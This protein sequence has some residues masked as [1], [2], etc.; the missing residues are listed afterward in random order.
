M[1]HTDNNESGCLTLNTCRDAD[2]LDLSR[3]GIIQ[4]AQNKKYDVDD[5]GTVLLH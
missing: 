5:D 3:V 4:R 2:R 1:W